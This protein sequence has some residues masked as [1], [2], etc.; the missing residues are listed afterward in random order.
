[1]FLTVDVLK[2]DFLVVDVIELDVLGA[3]RLSI[4]Y[5]LW[6]IIAYLKKIYV[7]EKQ[8]LETNNH[9]VAQT[10]KVDQTKKKKLR[11]KTNVLK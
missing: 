9:A 3:R 1:M 11:E 6:V 10:F 4:V 5:A 2:I 8:K 7:F